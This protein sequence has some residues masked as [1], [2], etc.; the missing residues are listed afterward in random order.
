MKNVLVA[1]GAG[2]IGSNLCDAL[3]DAG[4]RV[5]CLDNLLR[6]TK[7]NIAYALK[8]ERFTFTLGD[9]SDIRFLTRYMRDNKI[10]C[11]FHLAANSDIQASASDPQIEFQTTLSTTW[12]LLYAMRENHIKRFFFAST[13]AVYGERCDESL[14][15]TDTLA[16]ISYYGAAKTASEAFIHAFCHMNEMHAC[17]FRFA[18]VIGPRLTH[19]VIYDFIK[20]LRRDPTRLEVLGN[21]T[22]SKPYIYVDDLIRAIL[23]VHDKVSG[24][25]IY[26]VGV[27]SCTAVSK[28]AGI[29]ICEMGLSNVRI[30]Y[31]TEN[32]GW[33]GDVPRFQFDL[34]KIHATGWQA[35]LTSDQAVTA[36]VR[37]ALSCRR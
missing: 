9:A 3:L 25:E 33:K 6:G 32:I 14:V 11:V 23:L 5:F 16:P 13:S 17:I 4:Y 29:V 22:Q 30:E 10:E 8:N 34:S 18:N 27:D 7:E 24:V 35:D 1:G 36:A 26:N 28:I 31:G 12:A 15:E 21:G 2:F 19:G 37:E 20:K